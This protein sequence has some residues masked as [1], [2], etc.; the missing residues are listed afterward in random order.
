MPDDDVADE[1]LDVIDKW[2]A[3]NLR[4]ARERAGLSQEDLAQ[5]M[6][7]AGFKFH[8]Q[9]IGRIEAK[10]RSVRVGEALAFARIVKTN[11]DAL[12]RPPETTRQAMVLKG[13]TGRLWK[14]R[15]D[16]RGTQRE[17]AG[18]VERLE[19]LVARLKGSDMADV[20]AE[21]IRAA[22]RALKED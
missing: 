10:E 8:Q 4:A 9:T 2:F 18:A 21:E 20:L 17:I 11:L 14:L 19:A 5:R 13:A 6:R 7:E 3:V 12:A 16:L 15:D 22:E 1:R